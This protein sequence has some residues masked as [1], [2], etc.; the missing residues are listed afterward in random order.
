MGVLNQ[1]VED[2]IIAQ[3][4]IGGAMGALFYTEPFETYDLDI[5]VAFPA[6]RAI[7]TLDPIY[8][9]LRS[10]GYLEQEEHI[11]I[12][13]LP[14][15][16]LPIHNDLITEAAENALTKKIGRESA[17]VLR[18]EYLLAI[19]TRLSRAKDKIRIPLLL[20]QGEV[21]RQRLRD[22]LFRHGLKEKWRKVSPRS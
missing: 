13:G 3:Y 6:T 15:Q 11:V 20:E 21:D 7:I 1:M 4:V 16:F 10:K 19:M 17:R 14:V 2:G 8:E 9:Y 5:F 22:I 18:P 12:E